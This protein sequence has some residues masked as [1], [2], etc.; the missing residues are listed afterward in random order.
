MNYLQVDAEN[1]ELFGNFI[2][3]CVLL[4]F[5]VFKS[6]REN[7]NGGVR[8]RDYTMACTYVCEDNY[9]GGMFY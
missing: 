6:E 8:G 9:G 3:V 7:D 5:V 4:K 1:L 2:S